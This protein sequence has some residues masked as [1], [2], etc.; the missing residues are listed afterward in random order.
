MAKS[1]LARR[2]QLAEQ[3]PDRYWLMLSGAAN[4]IV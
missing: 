2:Q 4:Q 3:I 1:W